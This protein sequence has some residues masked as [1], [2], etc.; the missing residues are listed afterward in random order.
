[1]H[2]QAESRLKEVLRLQC[3]ELCPSGRHRSRRDPERRFLARKK[4]ENELIE[5]LRGFDGAHMTAVLDHRQAHVLLG[6]RKFLC[7]TEED[8][9]L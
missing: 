7:R 6:P 3:L 2:D 5:E 4:L 9:I 1:M 8:V